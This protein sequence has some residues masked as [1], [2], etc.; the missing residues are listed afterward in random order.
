MM[1]LAV[2]YNPP[3]NPFLA[4]QAANGAARCERMAATITA[5]AC[6]QNQREGSN[7][8]CRCTGC[9]G[10]NNQTP[11]P[12]LEPPALVLAWDADKPAATDCQSTTSADDNYFDGLVALDEII[13]GLYKD[14]V[15]GDSFDDV[16]LD[17]DDETLLA[18]FP[19]LAVDE[20]T[21]PDFPRFPERQE[22]A[23]RYAVYQG[24]CKKC[25]GYVE[26]YREWHDDEAFRCLSCGWRTGVEYENNRAM[27]EVT[28]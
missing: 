17:L 26:N 16:E 28:R 24:R 21:E 3:P 23:K 1:T 25:G 5:A 20:D 19:E 8:D 9:G 15:P 7:R 6:E 12:K 11:P 10:L 2:A 14:P 4:W 22:A 13:D 18:L 27:F